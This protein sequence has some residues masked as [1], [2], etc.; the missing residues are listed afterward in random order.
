ME[1]KTRCCGILQMF[2]YNT[3]GVGGAGVVEVTTDDEGVWGLLEA[4][5]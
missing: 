2:F 5:G 4:L 3:V 1:T